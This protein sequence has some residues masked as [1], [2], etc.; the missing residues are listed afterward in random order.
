MPEK[1]V[2]NAHM[3]AEQELRKHK[4]EAEWQHLKTCCHFLYS[5]L[6][7]YINVFHRYPLCIVLIYVY[8]NLLCER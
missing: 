2:K 1:I 8:F 6:G 4:K 5:H 7:L 3:L